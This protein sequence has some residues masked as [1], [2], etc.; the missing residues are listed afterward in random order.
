MEYPLTSS[1]MAF[2]PKGMPGEET[3]WNQGGAVIFQKKYSYSRINDAFNY[4][5]QIHEEL[6]MRIKKQ[7]GHLVAYIEEFKPVQYP[8]LTFSSRNEVIKASK[9]LINEP[10]SIFGPLI[11]CVVFETEDLSGIL[12]SAHHIIIDGFSAHVTTAFMSNYLRG[13]PFDPALIQSYAKHF[14]SEQQY[15]N[16]PR[17]ARAKN[18]WT[19]QFSVPPIP[20]LFVSGVFSVDYTAAE[21]VMNFPGALF[22][23]IAQF[24][25]FQSISISAFFATVIGTYI[26]Q[27]FGRSDFMLGIPVL[28][29]TTPQELNTTGLYMNILPL[30]IHLSMGGFLGCVKKIE[31]SKM[32]LL[33]YRKFPQAE[34]KSLL[35]EKGYPHSNLFDIIFDYQVF[36]ESEYYELAIQY[37]D[38]LSVPLEIHFNTLKKDLH[39][40]RIRYRTALFSDEQIREFYDRFVCIAA[41]AVENCQLPLEKIPQYSLSAEEKQRL[42]VDFNRTEFSHAAPDASTLYSLFEAQATVI[43]EKVCISAENHNVTFGQFRSYAEALDHKIRGIAKGKKSIVAIL[44][45]RSVEMYAAIYAAIRGG[46]AYLPIAPDYPKERIE[47]I[48]QDSGAA[49]VLAQEAFVPLAGNVP[50][51]DLT[52]FIAQPAIAAD[53]LPCAALPDDTA[54]VIYT[55]GSTGKPKGA[56][57]SHRS[58]VNRILWMQDAYPLDEQSLILQKTPYT[59]DVSVWEIFWWGLCGGSLAFSKPGEH[60]LPAKILQSVHT[61]QVTHLHF[62]PSVFDLFLTY[63]ETHPEKQSLFRSVQHVFLS[64]EALPSS[65][66]RRFYEIFSFEKVKLHNLYGPTE[67]AVDVTYYDCTPEDTEPIPIGRPIHNT[68]IYI[69]DPAMEPVPVGKTGELCIGGRNVGQ[70]YLNNPTLTAEKFVENPFGPGRLYKTGDY[71]SFREDGQILFGGRMDGQ[72]KLGGQRIEIGEIESVIRAIQGVETAAVLLCGGDAQRSLGACYCG[73]D[74]LETVIK[75]CCKQQ[76]PGY[77]VPTIVVRLDSMP[78][79]PS[80]KLDRRT[81]ESFVSKKIDASAHEPPQSE[82]EALICNAFSDVLHTASV[83]RNSSFFDL[84]GSSLDMIE[85]LLRDEFQDIPVPVFIQNPTPAALARVMRQDFVPQTQRIKCLRQGTPGAK[86]LVLFPYAGGGAEAFAKFVAASERHGDALSLY[87]MDY[88]HSVEECRGA[89]DELL[90][91]ADT[92]E[93]Y[94]YSHCAGSAPAMQIIRILED[95]GQHIIKHYIAGANIPF[96]QPPQDNFWNSVPD[97]ALKAVL[98]KAGASFATLPEEQIKIM[99]S[100]FRRDTDFLMEYFREETGK[101]QC[102][103]SVIISKEDFFTENHADAEKLWSNYAEDLRGVHFIG[104]AS[105]YFQSEYADTLLEMV[106][107]IIHS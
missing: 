102:P 47:Y 11:R 63:L 3:M 76:L 56:M 59:F 105:H 54:Y 90:R 38:S 58:A 20:P 1:Q 88:P 55:S 80:G 62:V 79:N 94:F 16:T 6:R 50:C 98:N 81:L 32:H 33:R 78:L 77:M 97:E 8:F 26:L 66:I 41:H 72:I 34:V 96:A 104:S 73:V 42:L 101:I 27:E 100:Q 99:L 43:P 22:E 19:E 15:R 92:A 44:A 74:G 2:Y 64:G 93:L 10:I 29:R 107:A 49:V 71:A 48:L 13:A 83:G 61:H 37:S 67:C 95:R 84:G 5:M 35:E 85:F 87:Y 103:L 68:S 60:F 18:Y 36:P 25:R 91:L 14:E 23:K 7:D 45:E 12:I 106:Q 86:A 30:A 69:L 52:D 51:I 17:Y 24:C 57:I 39:K 46:N 65:L 53:A 21:L 9:A 31:S 75:D 40:L 28:N 70:G 82:V 4:A 89:A